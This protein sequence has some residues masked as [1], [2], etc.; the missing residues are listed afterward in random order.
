MSNP[1]S[2]LQSRY[3]YE[4]RQSWSLPSKEMW[5][6]Y[7]IILEVLSA[8]EIQYT[9]KRKQSTI[10]INKLTFVRGIK[11][12]CGTCMLTEAAYSC[13]ASNFFFVNRVPSTNRASQKGLGKPFKLR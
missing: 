5:S 13:A 3:I 6:K 9:R 7:C 2:A 11:T 1:G 8:T 4:K 10:F 12:F